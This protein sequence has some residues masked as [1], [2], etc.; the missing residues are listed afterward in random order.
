MIK[1]VGGQL[2][3][4]YDPGFLGRRVVLGRRLGNSGPTRIWIRS[5]RLLARIGMKMSAVPVRHDPP[6]T[7]THILLIQFYVLLH[8]FSR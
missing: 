6:Y 1:P 4:Q 8:Y 2:K 5:G 3:A 7:P